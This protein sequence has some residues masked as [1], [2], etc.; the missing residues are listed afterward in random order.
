MPITQHPQH[1]TPKNANDAVDVAQLVD[2]V[3]TSCGVQQK[4]SD[5]IHV[6]KGPSVVNL[7]PSDLRHRLNVLRHKPTSE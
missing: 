5:S 7:S 2:Q 6:P 4:L 3:V 1:V